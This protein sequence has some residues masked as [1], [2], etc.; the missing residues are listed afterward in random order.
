MMSSMDNL[1]NVT[2]E[3]ADP[4]RARGTKT[5]RFSKITDEMKRHEASATYLVVGSLL[6]VSVLYAAV[7]S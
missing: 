4:S 1:S 2:V 5:H 6:V 7:I 3:N